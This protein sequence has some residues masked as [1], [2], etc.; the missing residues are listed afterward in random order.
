[1]V[2]LKT[3]TIDWLASLPTSA[4][5]QAL[6]AL[7][8]DRQVAALQALAQLPA[9][10]TQGESERDRDVA[11]KREMRSKATEITIPD[12]V[13]MRR[14][15]SAL[16]DPERFLRTYGARIFYNP[17][18]AHH[19]AMIAAI[20]QR[21]LT[22]GDKAVAAPRG[23]GKTQVATWM[24]IYMLLAELR[25]FPV[26]IAGNGTNAR[27]IFRQIQ[28]TFSDNELLVADFPEVCVP[29]LEL[30]G[31]PQRA[32]KQ[33]VRGERTRIIWTSRE[34]GLPYVPGSPYGGCYVTS[35]G[36]DCAIRGV[37]FDG[38]RP[39]FAL[40]DDPETREVAFSED[41]HKRIEELIDADVALLA[42]PEQKI[43]RVML[44]TIQNRR[45]YS[46]RVTD[47]TLK[48]AWEGERY[49]ALERLPDRADLWDEYISRR[50][51]AQT[52]GDKD[53]ADAQAFYIENREAMQAG[54][55]V[56]NPHRFVAALDAD[57]NPIELDALQAFYNKVADLGMARV[58]AELQNEPEEDR[59][60]VETQ[61]VPGIVQ[62]AVS[63]LRR[64]DLPEGQECRVFVGLDIGKYMSHWVK[65]AMW[66]NAVGHVID[67][68]VSHSAAAI[69]ER[70]DLQAIER[71]VL[72]MLLDW[73]DD[74]M[75]DNPPEL[76]MID[77]GFA[78]N[79]VYEF[80]RQAG[81]TP[82]LAAKG[83][84]N[85]N[86][87]FTGESKPTS[88][89]YDHCRAD[90]QRAEVGL[91]LYN[92]DAV[93]WKRAV[94][95]R[96]MVGPYDAEGRWKDG[97]LSVWGSESR[98]EHKTYSHHICAEI[99]EERFIE[100]KGVIGKWVVKQRKN[101][102][103]DATAMAL[104]AAGVAGFRVLPR[105]TQQ[106]PSKAPTTTPAP[107]RWTTRDGRPWLAS[108]RK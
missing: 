78:T 100:G 105:T 2:Q 66:G 9:A 63:K 56:S 108:E 89:Q 57:G 8:R 11:R 86:I 102:W 6:S 80:I 85:R 88:I 40:I 73:R 69:D 4:L 27:K 64:G 33:H 95:E 36:L 76:A 92:F 74:I 46:Y 12:P 28:A 29:V 16:Q 106:A 93:H 58:M 47:R 5:T 70:S 52:A 30:G 75:A 90:L 101:H 91:W 18:C 103:L 24:V 60:A 13:D 7:S 45:C 59:A 53:A 65:V 1:L 17:F 96:F 31:A 19:K 49:K 98:Q 83:H 20:Y 104:C 99:W 32:A 42:G 10:Q 43:A 39:D 41:Q 97:G 35:Y 107:R 21:A 71:A 34:I 51:Q 38:V 15:E 26:V 23:E 81:G 37:H 50:Q 77:T 14:R 48:P 3:E 22:G 54:A 82:F 87:N 68:G 72:R 44:T 62:T 55:I 84:D 67:Y 79:G 25:R 61:M 94:H